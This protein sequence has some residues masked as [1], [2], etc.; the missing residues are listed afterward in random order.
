MEKRPRI[1]PGLQD[2]ALSPLGK[3][4]EVLTGSQ[5]LLQMLGGLSDP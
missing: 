5:V 1:A 2:G 4:R 3:K